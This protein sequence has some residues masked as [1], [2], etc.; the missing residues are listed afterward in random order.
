MNARQA[1]LQSLER[2]RKDGAWLSAALDGIVKKEGLD[3]REASLASALA[4]GVLQNRDYY[5]FLIS[6]FCTTPV[7][8]LDGRVLDILRLGVCQL[9]ALDRIPPR[10]AVNETVTLCRSAGV[11]RASSLVNA[12][13]RK[14]AETRDRL[15]EVPGRGTAAYLATRYSHPLWLAERLVSE[16]GYDF[17]EAL[18]AADNAPAELDIQINTLRSSRAEYARLLDERGISYSLPAWPDSCICLSGAAVGELP[19]FE[20]GLFYVQDR[21]ARTA[22]DIAGLESGMRVLDSCASP[23]GKSLAAAMEMQGSGEIVSCDIHEKKLSLINN[24]AYRLGVGIIRTEFRDARAFV[25]GYENAF[26]AVIADVPCSGLGVIRK[27]PEIRF[28]REEEIAALPTIQRDILE[29]LSRYVRPGG[30]LLYCTCTILREENEAVVEEF[31]SSHTDFSPCDFQIGERASE[32]GCYTF[33]PHIDGTDGF[34]VAK[35]RRNA[36]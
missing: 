10:A 12:V 30:I 1:A 25:P 15:P 31:F 35:L 26:D 11:S 9:E 28:K 14:V 17:T 23:G 6:R 19:G 33:F 7:D 20:E 27:K 36:P 21:A 32:E 2:C 3:R 22:M 29:N 8:K 18:F 24:S 34:F 16:K 4:L 5:D 13:L